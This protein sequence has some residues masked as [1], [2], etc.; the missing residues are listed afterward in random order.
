MVATADVLKFLSRGRKGLTRPVQTPGTTRLFTGALAGLIGPGN[1]TSA[2]DVGDAIPWTGADNQI[3]FGFPVRP[4]GVK[5]HTDPLGRTAFD[6]V[7][8]KDLETQGEEGGIAQEIAVTGLTSQQQN[9]RRIYYSDDNT[10]T[11]TDPGFGLP[12][13]LVWKFRSAGVADVLFFTPLEML[14]MALCGTP[15]GVVISLGRLAS[16][17]FAAGVAPFLS[18]L[19]PFHGLVTKFYAVSKAAMGAAVDATAQLR[20]GGTGVTTGTITIDDTNF[21]GVNSLAQ[22]TPT[23]LNRVHKG[24]VFD[25]LLV[26]TAAVDQDLEFFVEIQPEVGI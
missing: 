25:V 6:V 3:P 23:A 1:T 26:E 20:I 8:A 9:M 14:I 2:D 19:A 12:Q 24:D 18:L 13:G 15:A 17:D 16:A 10:L 7:Q 4:V 5:L 11:L 22:V 21:P